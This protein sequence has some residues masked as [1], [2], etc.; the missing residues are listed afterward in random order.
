MSS[1]DKLKEMFRAAA[2][3]KDHREL[4]EINASLSTEL[5]LLKEQLE[6]QAALI[7]ELRERLGLNSDN[8]S[9]PPS[10]DGPDAPKREPKGR[11]NKKGRKQGAQPGHEGHSRELAPEDKVSKFVDVFPESCGSCGGTVGATDDEP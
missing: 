11:R 3:G 10:S 7:E 6:R 1:S 5:V 8:S 9:K 2:A 4:L